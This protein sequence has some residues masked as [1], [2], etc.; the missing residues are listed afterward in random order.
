M[1]KLFAISLLASLPAFAGT[2]TPVA[3]EPAPQS[4]MLTWFAGGSVG[5]LTDFEEAM[6]TAHVGVDTC[7]KLAGFDIAFFGEVGY[8]EKDESWGS[9]SSTSTYSSNISPFP[10]G[11]NSI[12]DAESYLSSSTTRLQGPTSFDLAI[13]PI[14]G[15]IKFERAISGNL[16]AY[17]G[18][19]LGLAYVDF[20]A[21]APIGSFS[22]TD[23]VFVGQIFTGL[24]YNVNPHFEIFGGAR[25]IYLDDIDVNG[26]GVGGKHISGSVDL[27]DDF[28]F[29]LGA[30]YNF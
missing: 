6:Y 7:W 18:A 17:F 15:N 5:Y 9:V 12:G 30:R 11:S 29:E 24:T 2:P 22:E 8:T 14:T 19:G 20:S 23:W 1:K 3:S 21:D 13:V 16:N 4:D 26:T 25:W 10:G 27:G 28:L